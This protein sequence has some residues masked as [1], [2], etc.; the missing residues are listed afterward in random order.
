MV[1]QRGFKGPQVCA[2]VGIT[3]RQLDYWARTNLVRPSLVDAQGSGSSRRYAYG[4]LL[5]L[6]LVK[7]LLDGGLSLPAVR[8]AMA[9]VKDLFDSDPTMHTYIVVGPKS[10]YLR[11]GEDVLNLLR[12]GQLGMGVVVDFGG[13]RE[14]LEI[15]IAK[16]AP[17]ARSEMQPGL[18]FVD[19]DE[20]S[21][22]TAVS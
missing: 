11:D 7:R 18:P 4:D 21:L 22:R 10:V 6:K 17:P 19:P 9:Q 13:V 2:V 14:D 12:H 3:Y 16:F 8:K 5:M 20:V 1:E 15:T